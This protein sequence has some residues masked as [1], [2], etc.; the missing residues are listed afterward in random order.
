LHDVKLATARQRHH[1]LLENH[2]AEEVGNL[3]SYLQT[4]K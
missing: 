3:V 4:V 1:A 2:T